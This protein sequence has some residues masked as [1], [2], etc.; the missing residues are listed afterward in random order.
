ML[1]RLAE[2]SALTGLDTRFPTEA[3]KVVEDR[4]YSSRPRGVGRP[5]VE[6][7]DEAIE[8][9]FMYG[10]KVKNIAALYGV[11]RWTVY[12]RM[13]H[14]GLR[15]SELYSGIDNTDLDRLVLEI[16]REHPR[17]GYRM[18]RAFLQAIARVRES[19]QRVD[20]EGTQLR[21]LANR[22]LHRRHWRFVIHGGIDGFSRLIVYLNAATNNNAT[23]VLD[24]FLRAVSQ[25]GLPSRVCSDK[26]GENIEVA[27]FMVQNRG[28]NRNSHITGRSVH[29][30]R[31]E[32]LWR[33]VYT[34]VLDLFHELFYHLEVTGLL[35]PDDEIHLFALHW[36]FLPQLKH[37]LNSFKEAW[38][39]HRLRTEN[40]RSPYQLWLQNRE[41]ADDPETV[42]DE[43]GVD[44]DGPHAMEDADNISIP[45][46]ELPR[47]LT[48]EETASLPNREVPL[49]EAVDAYLSTVAQLTQIFRY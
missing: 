10:L 12:R 38:N 31:I 48:A 26:G 25:Y 7:P 43:Y 34:Q 3:L 36:T 47:H 1:E 24:A 46:A 41:A 22:T 30:Q 35:N 37:Q 14:C 20:P 45:D 11:S 4:L 49:N 29:N 17:C 32:R 13:Q 42:D 23:T 19:L 21:A 28:E 27:H 9:Y 39:L 18:M 16:H 6:I 33:D 44:W 5:A 15:V 2:L 8:G 40:G